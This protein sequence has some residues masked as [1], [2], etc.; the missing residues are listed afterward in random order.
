MDG[1]LRCDASLVEAADRQQAV[2]TDI[3]ASCVIVPALCKRAAPKPDLAPACDA[4]RPLRGGVARGSE[5]SLG[6]F[7]QD[8]HVQSLIG[9]QLLEPG[10]LFLKCTQL[11]GHLW[12]H[13]AVLL[14]PAVVSL[15][16]DS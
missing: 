15:L 1:D 12:S 14:T 6:G 8:Q 3:A 5:V 11:L 13:A 16:S 7:L 10:I 9:D 4:P 2:S